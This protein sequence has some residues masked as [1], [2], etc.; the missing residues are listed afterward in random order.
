MQAG[1]DA[2]TAQALLDEDD[3]VGE[4]NSAQQVAERRRVLGAKGDRGCNDRAIGSEAGEGLGLGLKL[5]PA[6]RARRRP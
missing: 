5:W 3:A 2:A 1:T 4:T 6:P